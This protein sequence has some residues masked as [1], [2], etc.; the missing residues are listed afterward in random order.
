MGDT[1]IVSQLFQ[2]GLEKT[3]NGSTVLV[4][5]RMD[6][7]GMFDQLA[8]GAMTTVSGLVTLLTTAH[9][10]SQL[11]PQ[12]KDSYSEFTPPSFLDYV[13]FC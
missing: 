3:A 13:F 6:V 10:L 8:P 9:L 7:A 5:A 4:T 2:R 1:N 12:R 11:L